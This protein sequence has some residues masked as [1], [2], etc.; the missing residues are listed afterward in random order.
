MLLE[1][2]N[3]SDAETVFAELIRRNP[4]NHAY[5]RQMEKASGCDTEE[6]RINMYDGYREKYP[7]ATA[8]QRLPLETATGERI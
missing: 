2:G 4:E 1:S 8:P 7:K 3:T 6:K 5:Y